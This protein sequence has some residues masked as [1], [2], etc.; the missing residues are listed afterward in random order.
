[1]WPDTQEENLLKKSLMENLFIV[2]W[3]FKEQVAIFK[4]GHK[5]FN[6]FLQRLCWQKTEWSN[7]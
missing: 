5:N 6:V 1:M 2:Q 4:N 3:K 7:S